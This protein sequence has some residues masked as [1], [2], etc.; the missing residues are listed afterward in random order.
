MTIQMINGKYYLVN[1]EPKPF[2]VGR[3]E[4]NRRFNLK[5]WHPGASIPTSA[6]HA[7]HWKK[8]VN[9]ELVEGEDYQI[10]SHIENVH[11]ISADKQT[12]FITDTSG[13]YCLPI[14]FRS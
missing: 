7:S 4:W 6:N 14:I 9:Q 10:K 3:K 8:L 13:T 5:K 11:T 1:I 12:H 2:I